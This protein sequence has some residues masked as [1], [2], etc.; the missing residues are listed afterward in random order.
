M[1]FHDFFGI[2]FCIDF[3]LIL[4]GKLIKNGSKWLVPRS[5][6]ST[7]EPTFFRYR[8]LDASW[9]P[10]GSLGAP[11]GLPLAPFGNL[12]GPFCFHFESFGL[13]FGHFWIHFEPFWFHSVPKTTQRPIFI[14]F[15]RF[16]MNLVTFWLILSTRSQKPHTP[17]PP[18]CLLNP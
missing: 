11:F 4:N 16:F 12:F 10:F 1:I 6:P 7:R 5:I 8:F 13:H 18:I 14:D 9:S 17:Q 15:H 2:D 3:S